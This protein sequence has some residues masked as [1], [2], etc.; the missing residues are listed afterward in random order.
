MKISLSVVIFFF[1]SSLQMSSRE[2]PK[3]YYFRNYKIGSVVVTLF[4]LWSLEYWV[5]IYQKD[6]NVHLKGKSS[7]SWHLDSWET[8]QGLPK[9]QNN[10]LS[11]IYF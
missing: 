1:P 4:C 11:K 6:K 7:F 10:P 9:Y 5:T 3:F 8:G 2:N